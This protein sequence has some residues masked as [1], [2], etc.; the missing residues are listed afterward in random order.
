M[1]WNAIEVKIAA[2]DIKV[3]SLCV[4]NFFNVKFSA[5]KQ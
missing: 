1:E 3:D 4:A 5:K 2:I